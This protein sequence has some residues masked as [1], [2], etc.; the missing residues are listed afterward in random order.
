MTVFYKTKKTKS[1]TLNKGYTE[2]I[3]SSVELKLKFPR[4]I[5]NV[6]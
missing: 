6:F 3:L 2:A 5:S 1:I 4:C